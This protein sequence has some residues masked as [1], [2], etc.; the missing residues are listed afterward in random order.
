MAIVEDKALT[1]WGFKKLGFCA[2][3]A[4]NS[5]ACAF[6]WTTK[7]VEQVALN[8]PPMLTFAGDRK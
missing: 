1:G 3:S 4:N 2:G 8:I 6:L 5:Q 7:T